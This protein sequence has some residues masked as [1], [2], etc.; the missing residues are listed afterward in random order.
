MCTDATMPIPS[1]NENSTFKETD[2]TNIEVDGKKV[3][4]Y[5]ESKVQAEKAADEFISNWNSKPGNKKLEMSTIQP[6][7]ILGPLL[8][9]SNPTS[10]RLVRRFL[11]E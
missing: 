10:V 8:N 1:E 2:W 4:A 3:D 9:K 6:G 5:S 11:S 7:M